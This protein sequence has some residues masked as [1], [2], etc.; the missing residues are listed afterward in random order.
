MAT[1]NKI[2]SDPIQKAQLLIEGLSR[3]REVLASQ[4][5]DLTYIDR[6]QY[7]VDELLREGQAV[8]EE[9][10]RLSIHRMKCHHI[11]DHLKEDL[12]AGKA[13]I[14]L[15]FAQEEWPNYGVVDKR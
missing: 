8:A 14:K 3:N 2:Y 7:N 1:M 15:R 6:L 10:E 9:E 11:L 13:G 5:Y 12:L 4:G